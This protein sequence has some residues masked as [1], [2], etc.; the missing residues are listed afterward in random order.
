M[1]YLLQDVYEDQEGNIQKILKIG[2]SSKSFKEGRKTSYDTHNYGYKLLSERE[3]SKELEGYLHKRFNTL[4]LSGEWFKYNPEI[5]RLFNESTED[6]IIEVFSQEDINEHI[7]YYILKNLVPSVKDLSDRYLKSLLKELELLSFTSPEYLDLGFDEK[8]IKSKIL[9]VFEFVV[10]K[11]KE[12]YMN[13]NFESPDI[14]RSLE[15]CLLTLDKNKTYPSEDRI[16]NFY[17]TQKNPVTREDF[18]KLQDQRRNSTRDLLDLY[19]TASNTQKQEYIKKLKSDIQL[20]K[21]SDDFVA[22][23]SITNLPVYNSL[24]EISNERA[25]E[26]SQKDYQDNISVTKA[27]KDAGFC[28]ETYT[29]EQDQIVSEFLDNHFY[30]T[31][32][33]A[34][35]MK[36]Y[37]E[38][39]DAY[40]DSPEVLAALIA[41]IPDQKFHQYYD[42]YGTKGCS[43]RKYK[44]IE[45]YRGW[46]DT[47]KEENLRELIFRSFKVGGKYAKSEIKDILNQIY[48]KLNLT[49]KAKATDLGEYFKLI[50]TKVTI[51]NKTI[52]HGFKL[53]NL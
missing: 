16:K 27:L 19:S 11:E 35:K 24:I 18:D 53:E 13:L 1:L 50:G 41:K 3:G 33:F 15:E 22:I 21:Y 32:I 51:P 48:Q 17:K 44:E 12:Y 46:K 9:G 52:V 42:Y 10:S 8:L 2:Y 7:R 31:G 49:R 4:L 40:K 14:K 30:S 43:S 20:R 28:L 29:S 23:S 45:L 38:F 37:C 26:V 25:W 5:I 36:M 47:T 6:S 39:R 34:E